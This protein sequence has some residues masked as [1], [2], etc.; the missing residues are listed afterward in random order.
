MKKLLVING[1]NLNMT[2]IRKRD[3]YG[4]ETLKAINEELKIY[5]KARGARAYFFQHMRMFVSKTRFSPPY[6]S[7]LKQRLKLP[8]TSGTR[9][10]APTRKLR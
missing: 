6:G 1:P 4:S 8:M 7:D 3:V 2:G 10:S 5:A 9:G